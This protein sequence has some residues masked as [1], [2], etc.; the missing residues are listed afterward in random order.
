L[1]VVDTNIVVRFAVNDDADQAVMAKGLFEN[2]TVSI[3]RTVAL[4]TEWVL[5]SRYGKARKQIA[6]Y[7]DML[8]AMKSVHAH[9]AH[10][11]AGQSGRD[12]PYTG[13][14]RDGDDSDLEHRAA[15]QHRRRVD[16]KKRH[17]VGG[18]AESHRG[19]AARVNR[20]G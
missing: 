13:D 14:R 10:R 6:E 2:H 18:P 20:R 16:E 1:I 11:V 3:S 19:P 12:A 17:D 15:H 7:F 5:R 4:E 8:L 9:H